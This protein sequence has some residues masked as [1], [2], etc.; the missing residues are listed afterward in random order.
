MQQLEEQKCPA[1]G[2]PMRFDPPAGKLVC[3]Y[4]DTVVEIPKKKPAASAKKEDSVQGFDF[5]QLNS[6]A[7]D[8]SAEGLP[9]FH[10]V[11]C[12]AEVIAPAEQVATTC[13]YCGNNIVLTDK[14]SGSLRPDGLI[15][16]R[17]VS[18]ELPAAVNRFYRNKK[19]LPKGFFSES[20]MGAVT[21]VYLPFWVFSGGLS[22]RMTFEGERSSSRREGDYIVTTT[23]FYQLVR[24]SAMAFSDV[25]V[26]ASGKVD[27]KLMDSLEPFDMGQVQPFDMRY[28]AGFTADRFDIGRR[29]GCGPAPTAWSSAGREKAMPM[30]E[31]PEAA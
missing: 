30:C 13:P 4:C 29:S 10:C 25:P 6:Q 16:F 27:D 20:T 23:D 17:I 14:V 1:C 15:P 5:S 31:G 21:G 9:V 18:G 7:V 28:L 26:D 19:L 3:D 8:E 24:D 11:S 12:G 22:G 2:A